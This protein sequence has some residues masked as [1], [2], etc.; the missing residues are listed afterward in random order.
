MKLISPKNPKSGQKKRIKQAGW[1]EGLAYP[2]LQ[3]R[4]PRGFGFRFNRKLGSFA[5][6]SHFSLCLLQAE[7]FC[8]RTFGLF[9]AMIDCR[10]NFSVNNG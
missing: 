2:E 5:R 7:N 8:A 6:G 9:F 3:R 4:M 1:R 10:C